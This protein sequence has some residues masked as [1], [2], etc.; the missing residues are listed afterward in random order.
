MAFA[1]TRYYA[2]VN[3][4][5]VF[6]GTTAVAGVKPPAYNATAHTFCLWNPLGS[7]KNF[8][9]MHLLMGWSDTTGATGNVCISYQNG[10]GSQVATGGAI[11]AATLVAPLNAKIGAGNSS[12]A[13]FAPATATFAAATS[14]L[15]ST[16]ITQTVTTA[17][18]ATN[19]PNQ[20]K[21]DFEGTIMVPPGT[22]IC[23]TGNIALLSNFDITLIWAEVALA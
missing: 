5:N 1:S 6:V 22:A 9:P 8:I 17:T 20:A 23:V 19:I 21:H 14:L 10:V 18:D 7:N 12:A 4:G 13:K 2:D 11:T 15:M 16:G 3:A